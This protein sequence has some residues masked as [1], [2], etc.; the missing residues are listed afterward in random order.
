MSLPK[1]RKYSK[2]AIPAAVGAAVVF[3]VL[4][5]APHLVNTNNYSGGGNNAPVYVPTQHTAS[6]VNDMVHV[7][8][9]TYTYYTFSAPSGSTNAYV[10]GKFTAGGGSGNDI[11]VFIM[12]DQ[13][14]INWRNGHQSNVYYNSGQE[15]VGNINANIPSGQTLYLIYDNTFSVL[16]SK[17]VST[18]VS[19]TYTS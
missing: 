19:L 10:S 5:V 6:L 16:S 9:H 7:N 8:A 14:F 12:D 18:D 4:M 2:L 11:R 17:E 15:T 3:V 13:N 1:Q